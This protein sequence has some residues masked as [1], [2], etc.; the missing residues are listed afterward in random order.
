MSR[1]PLQRLRAHLTVGLT[2][3]M[4]KMIELV[5]S[6]VIRPEQFLTQKTPIQSAIDAYRSFARHEPGLDQG[7]AGPSL[8]KRHA[9]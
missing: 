6:G 4:P 3:Y 5:R 8:G 9:A 1:R 7:Q 2:G